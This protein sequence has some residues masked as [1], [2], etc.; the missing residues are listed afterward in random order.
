MST[1]YFKEL[2]CVKECSRLT[3][4]FLAQIFFPL[5]NQK[6]GSVC[7]I[8]IWGENANCTQ[9]H[10]NRQFKVNIP[11]W[12]S[13]LKLT[14]FSS[15]HS[16]TTHAQGYML[17]LQHFILT[18]HCFILLPENFMLSPEDSM[19][20]PQD[21]ILTTRIHSNSTMFNANPQGFMLTPQDSVLTPKKSI[22]TPRNSLLTPIESV[23]TQDSVIL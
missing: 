2:H 8:W 9:F 12:S 10:N 14:Q 20:T 6:Q 21:F 5:A 15:K 7:F 22:Q 19:L 16:K 17:P 13:A 1:I 4:I 23:L 3:F 18:P 11:L